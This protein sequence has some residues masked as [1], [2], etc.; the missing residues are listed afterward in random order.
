MLRSQYCDLPKN[1]LLKGGSQHYLPFLILI[2]RV[3]KCVL[4]IIKWKFVW[5]LCFKWLIF[6]TQYVNCDVKVVIGHRFVLSLYG[7]LDFAVLSC[8]F[9]LH[10]GKSAIPRT[11][12][13]ASPINSSLVGFNPTFRFWQNL[14]F[15]RLNNW[16]PG[17]WSLDCPGGVAAAGMM[18]RYFCVRTDTLLS[19]NVGGDTPLLGRELQWQRFNSDVLINTDLSVIS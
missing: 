10:K 7:T 18:V 16:I 14:K 1:V 19:G 3:S 9:P 15:I 11:G 2:G 17:L 12:L 5:L 6:V 13:R 8:K 4:Q